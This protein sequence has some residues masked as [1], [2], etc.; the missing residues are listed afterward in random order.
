MIMASK[1]EKISRYLGKIPRK[2]FLIGLAVVAW[3]A[4]LFVYSDRAG[5]ISLRSIGFYI[6]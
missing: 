6:S 5:E 4:L 1:I 2:R 3:I